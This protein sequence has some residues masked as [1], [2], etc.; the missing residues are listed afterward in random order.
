MQDRKLKLFSLELEAA[1]DVFQSIFLYF[2]K[3]RAKRLPQG[4]RTLRCATPHGRHTPFSPSSQRDSAPRA[5]D[6]HCHCN[7]Q[8]EREKKKKL[9][10]MKQRTHKVCVGKMPAVQFLFFTFY[11]VPKLSALC[12]QPLGGSFVPGSINDE[13][14]SDDLL[15]WKKHAIGTHIR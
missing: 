6:S 3:G 11:F 13:Y 1:V 12:L 8:V 2:G 7:F 10:I 9:I 14:V 4:R 5:M 15:F